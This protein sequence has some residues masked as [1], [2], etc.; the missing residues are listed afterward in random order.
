V[1]SRIFSQHLDDA[2]L[3]EVWT[4]AA[5]DGKAP[6]HPH[7]EACA[8]CRLRFTSFTAWLDEV[9]DVATS[10]AE[11][12]FPAERLTAQQHQILRR[13]EAAD[14]PTRV[15]AF[16]KVSTVS[17]RPSPVRRWVTAAAAAGLVAGIGLGQV[18][19]LRHLSSG[20]STFPEDRQQVG[21]VPVSNPAIVP[22]GATFTEDVALAELEAMAT[23]RYEALRP[24]DSFTPRVA[25]L[26]AASR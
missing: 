1:L 19:D 12:V 14:E 2:A 21:T 6:S 23:P 17:T 18:F 10:E 15:I 13:L 5:A 7:L 24:Y 11:L 8:E 25:D 20:A 26:I 3:A 4:N 22:A 9:Q 16:P